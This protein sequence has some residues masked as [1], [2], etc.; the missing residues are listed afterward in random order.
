MHI[1]EANGGAGPA[2]DGSGSSRQRGLPRPVRQGRWARLAAR[3]SFVT[4]V[5]LVAVTTAAS[6]CRP[7]SCS[8]PF[9]AEMWQEGVT[10]PGHWPPGG[11]ARP[12]PDSVF[13]SDDDG[14]EDIVEGATGDPVVAMTVHRGDGDLVFT[15]AFGVIAA[16]ACTAVLAVVS[17]P[18]TAMSNHSRRTSSD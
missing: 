3:R 10:D 7:P 8:E 17:S 1:V 18:L 16:K 15:S 9:P 14:Y 11:T 13:D 5:L 6:G 4:A 12:G 2:A